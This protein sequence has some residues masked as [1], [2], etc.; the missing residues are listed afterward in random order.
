MEMMRAP[1]AAPGEQLGS[2]T[3]DDTPVSNVAR[4]FSPASG[5]PKGPH[6]SSVAPREGLVH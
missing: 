1:D 6:Y 4:G 3:P 2:G 5:G